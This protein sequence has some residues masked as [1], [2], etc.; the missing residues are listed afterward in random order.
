MNILGI[1]T[2]CDETCAS[3]VQDGRKILSNVVASSAD[4]HERYGGV[5]PELACRRHLDAIIP[6]IQ[7][8]IVAPVDAIAV[9]KG[10]G[11]IGAILIGMQVAKGLSICWNKPLTFVNHVEAHIYA[12]LMGQEPHQ[13]LFPSLGIVLSGGHTFLVKM[14]N[15]GKYEL[16]STTV[17]DAIGEAFDKVGTLL[18]LSYPG[19]PKVEKLARE[20]RSKEFPFQAG[21]VKLSPHNFSFSGLK[22]AVLYAV[23]DKLLDHQMKCDIAASFQETALND[24]LK[25]VELAIQKFPC[26]AIYFGGGVTSNLRLKELFQERFSNLPLFFP[27][28]NLSLDNG[29]MIGGL[30]YHQLLKNPQGDSL[31]TDAQ[32]RI[33]L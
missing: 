19:G 29:A 25:K 22:T 3:L 12:A 15:I 6:V 16:L 9:A 7:E 32:T 18:G 24:V 8:A 11:L 2:T 26:L 28:L 33:P 27:P 17:D 14:E 13:W 5:F 23:K 1:E 21:K 10:P 30:G 31:L 4:I 20:G